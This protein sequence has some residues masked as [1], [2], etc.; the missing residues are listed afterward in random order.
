MASLSPFLVLL[1]LLVIPFVYRQRFRSASTRAAFWLKPNGDSFIFHPFGRRGRAYLVSSAAADLIKARLATRTKIFY[2]VLLAAIAPSL[3]FASLDPADFIELRPYLSLA[4]FAVLA[5]A[6]ISIWVW[7]R[8]AIH[9]LYTDAPESSVRI[10][11]REVRFK[12]AASAS[13]GM[14]FFTLIRLGMLV[15][16]LV[17]Y[18]VQTHHPMVVGFSVLPLVLAT[19][20]IRTI[21]F[22]LQPGY[23]I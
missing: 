15:G 20:T 16:G 6:I 5:V 2:G 8:L 18:G 4:R 19:R 11:L 9:P 17:W 3:I 23:A 7:H 1:A 13:W 10:P 14:I 21:Y 12:Q 22:K